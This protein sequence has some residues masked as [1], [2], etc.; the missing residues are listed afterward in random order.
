MDPRI[1]SFISEAEK[2]IEA[3]QYAVALE[4]LA[5]AET[6]DP[7]NKSVQMIR[8]LV[9]SLQ[10]DQARRSPIRRPLTVTVD[11]KAPAIMNTLPEP[12]SDVQKRIRS[13]TGNAD[14]YLSR[15]AIDNAFE[16]LM[17]AYLLD[18]V[19]PEVLACEE[20]VLPAYRRFHGKSAEETRE[21]WKID[22]TTGKPR[23]ASSLFDR[24]RNGKFLK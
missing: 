2:N 10:A 15:G 21:E 19:A 8:D 22:L 16:S 17:R 11:A 12:L 24:L 4:A 20:R 5:A 6:I 3:R 13:L 9:K 18:P 14:Y 23:I 7:N 1:T